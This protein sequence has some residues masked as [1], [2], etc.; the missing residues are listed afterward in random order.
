MDR[1]VCETC[2]SG[3]L[4]A[5]DRTEECISKHI[6]FVDFSICSDREDNT[7]VQNSLLIAFRLI[8][9]LYPVFLIRK[10][11]ERYRLLKEKVSNIT[12]TT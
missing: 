7:C 2:V 5:F 1:F 12:I 11:F 4:Y 6:R 3:K 10:D 9:N 8:V